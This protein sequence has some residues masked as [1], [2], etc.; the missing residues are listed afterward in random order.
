MTISNGYATLAEFKALLVITSTDATDD[1]VIENA[2]EAASRFID[3]K[4]GRRFYAV[5]ETRYF[6]IPEEGSRLLKLDEDLISITTLTNGDGT[7]ITSSYYNLVPKNSSPYC[8]VKMKESS[9]YYWCQ[10]T[11]GNTEDVISIAGSWGFAATAPD[12]VKEACLQI[13]LA[14]Y[15]RKMGENMGTRTTI[16]AFG[17]TITPEDIPAYAW[18]IIK[19]Y[20]KIL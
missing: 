7:V 10:D 20:R 12:D 8:G 11:D 3:G 5:T 14:A 6:D 15:K 9:I 13:A 19:Y 2:I 17:V 18:G 1:A 16:T 4:T